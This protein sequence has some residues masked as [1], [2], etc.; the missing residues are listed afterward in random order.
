MGVCHG[1]ILY[2]FDN[3]RHGWR[4]LIGAISRRGGAKT[5]ARCLLR[6]AVQMQGLF[7]RHTAL[8]RSPFAAV[9]A[10]RDG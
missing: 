5:D 2:L 6:I 7:S 10:H 3:K 4:R 9:I 8:R 1:R